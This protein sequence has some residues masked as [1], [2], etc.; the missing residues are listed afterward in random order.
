MYQAL[1]R[2]WRPKVF[3][4]VVGQDHITETLKSEVIS[5]RISHAYLF[6]G[7]RGTG[8]TSCAKI[9]AKA[10]NCLNNETGSPCGNC[11]ICKDIDSGNIVDIT[12]ID[13]ASNNGVDNVRSMRDELI[14][15]PAKC[16][17]RVYI[18]DEVH[19]FSTGAFNALLKVLEEPPSHVI[20]I[21]ATTEI[22]KIPATII[23]R[24]QRFDFKR[25][26]DDD[27]CKRM[28]YICEQEGV[29][30]DEGAKKIIAKSACGGM[31]D[32]L[33]ILDQ[34]V[35]SCSGD[36]TE[37][38][39]REILGFYDQNYIEEIFENINNNNC[40]NCLKLLEKAY[41]ESKSMMKLC[42]ELMFKYE[43]MMLD[44]VNKVNE[45]GFSLD[46][47]IKSLDIL[48]K[49]YSN[50]HR[51]ANAK[52]ELEIAFVKLF[53]ALYGNNV[54]TEN[55]ETKKD[56]IIKKTENVSTDAVATEVKPTIKPHKELKTQSKSDTIFTEWADVLNSLKD[57]STLKS[58]YISLRD[59]T[60]YIRDDYVLIDSKN[61]LSFE[62][63][64]NGSYRVAIKKIIKDITGRNYKLGP[65]STPSNDCEPLDNKDAV[66]EFIE[67]VKNAGIEV[68]LEGE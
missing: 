37:E 16:R 2:K 51:G 18:V 45:K 29:N 26:S 62:L 61:S 60:A 20:F 48:Q 28:S 44:K 39:V 67:N 57:T 14:F 9:L 22:H 23:S 4:D 41:M 34:V 17:Y 38:Y 27:I 15:T 3:D 54:S 12:E 47:I 30:I 58:L 59:S 46:K 52:L 25:I 33:S 40:L 11:E 21:L 7:S 35:N 50:L 49:S 19:M 6:V 13:A 31:R 68:I 53:Q 24:C 8:K 5:G 32:A 42:E 66:D 1:Y 56:E 63:L 65:Y 10:V 64:R 43:T 55:K 36:I